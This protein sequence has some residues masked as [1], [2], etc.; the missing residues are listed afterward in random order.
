VVIVYI[1][2]RESVR[3]CMYSSKPEIDY[4]KYIH[5]C[6]RVLVRV[7]YR[8]VNN[9]LFCVQTYSGSV[10]DKHSCKCTIIVMYIYIYMS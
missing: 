10:F 3:R 8:Y 1:Y 6:V 2:K 5:M 9:S 4:V 7:L